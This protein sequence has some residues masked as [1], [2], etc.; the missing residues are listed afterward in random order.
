MTTIQDLIKLAEEYKLIK[1]FVGRQWIKKEG[2]KIDPRDF[3][4]IYSSES[5]VNSKHHHNPF[6][7]SVT[8]L[9]TNIGKIV[10]IYDSDFDTFYI[11]PELDEEGYTRRSS[12]PVIWIP[13]ISKLIDNYDNT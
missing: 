11:N 4:E 2:S 5:Q 12:Y 7:Y 6:Y 9:R 3:T 8:I 13:R 1:V 10:I